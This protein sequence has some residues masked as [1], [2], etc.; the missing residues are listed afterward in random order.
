MQAAALAGIGFL[1]VGEHLSQLPFSD[2]RVPAFYQEIRADPGD[3]AVLELPLAWR[4]GFRV[5]GALED[6]AG[7]AFMR[8]QL[9]QT[10]HEKRMLSGNTSR[11]PELQFQY[12]TEAPVIN[13]L[14]ALETGHDVDAATLAIDKRLAPDVFAF[15]GIRYVVLRPEAGPK[16]GPYLLS[17]LPGLTAWR[18]EAGVQVYR[19]AAPAPA[20]TLRIDPA[21]PVARLFFGEGWGELGEKRA[22]AQRSDTRL[23]LPMAGDAYT[24]SLQLNAPI[25]GQQLSVE[26]NGHSSPKLNLTTG[27]HR[28]DIALD[29]ALVH[30][31]VNSVNLHWQSLYAQGSVP[32]SEPSI[33]VKSAGEEVGDFAHIWVNGRDVSPN[34]RGLN[35]AFFGASNVTVSAFDTFE[36]VSESERLSSALSGPLNNGISLAVRDE[37]SQKLTAGAK[38]ALKSLGA[39]TSLGWRWS[40]AFLRLPQEGFI[41]EDASPIRPAIVSRGERI[42]SPSVAGAVESIGLRRAPDAP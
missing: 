32:Q 28:Y 35:A 21:T 20:D 36:S 41:R 29:Q 7:K 1:I 18:S 9:Y 38:T 19:W 33:V 39:R 8:A 31:G 11:N 25:N 22:W 14:I 27:S 37:A 16:L 10:V 15:F 24:L 23:L 30:P 26:I 13:S 17:V 34:R 40:F 3:F 5:T 12:F 6:S 4:N 2:V 42:T